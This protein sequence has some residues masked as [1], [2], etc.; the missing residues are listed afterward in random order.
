MNPG[1]RVPEELFELD[2]RI[3]EWRPGDAPPR[4]LPSVY[5]LTSSFDRFPL[6]DIWPV[7]ARGEPVRTV[8]TLYDLIPLVFAGDYLGSWPAKLAYASRLRLC[9]PRISSCRSPRSRRTTAF[10]SSG[11]IGPPDVIWGGVD[12]ALPGL[13]PDP[14]GPATS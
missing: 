5:H 2:V 13:V 1:L 4:P 10:V 7:W 9:G 3:L 6:R 14:S 11:S 8:I 12:P